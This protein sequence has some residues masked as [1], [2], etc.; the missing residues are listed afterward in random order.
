MALTSVRDY[1][2]DRM[3]SLNYN[4]WKDGFNF[5][6]IPQTRYERAYHIETG[7]IAGNPADNRAFKYDYPMT[8]RVFLKG[9]RDPA[10][11]IDNAVAQAEVIQA[12]ILKESN[13]LGTE[14]KT[15]TPNSIDISPRDESNDNDIILTMTFTT[16]VICFFS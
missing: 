15:I 16:T 9:F 6:N 4:E 5:D 7:S 1:Y 11:A 13:R 2:R 14:I 8:V 12:D 3:N 10:S